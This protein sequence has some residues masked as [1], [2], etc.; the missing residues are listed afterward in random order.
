MKHLTNH[1]LEF[2]K[3]YWL[4]LLPHYIFSRITY[5]ITRTKNP[6]VPKLIKLYISF[7]KVNMKECI[8]ES[9]NDYE[10]FCDF[11]TRE[12][13]PG[14]HKIDKTKKSIVSSCD[15]TITQY[16]DIDNNT[17]LQV[18]GKRISIHDLMHE[19]QKLN[20]VFTDGSF[21]T[22][23]LSP[24]DYH[25]VHMPYSGKLIST[26]HIPGRLF[27]VAKHA[28]NKINNLYA[29]NERL[30]CIFKN[31]DLTFAVIFIAAINVSSI[32]VRWK[33]EIS[34]PY[35]KKTITTNYNKKKIIL[36][37]GEELGMFK[38]GSTVIVL[39]DKNVKLLSSIKKGQKIR[40][41]QKIGSY[42]N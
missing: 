31:E 23:Y 28:V 29:R 38:S 33:G 14:I 37:K 12:L 35:P 40:V 15:G 22:I 36:D 18:K 10:T 21:M 34:P 19:K 2:V 20:D 25:R 8:N 3:A 16:G 1:I 11:F 42:L 26:S 4:F 5:I 41:G 9:P 13:K 39:F 32:E 17:I 7:F 30:S 24:K 27:S 6:F